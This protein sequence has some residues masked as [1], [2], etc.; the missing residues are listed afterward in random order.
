M[1]TKQEI[2]IN[3]LAAAALAG[4]SLLQAAMRQLV[5]ESINHIRYSMKHGDDTMKSSISRSMIPYL[6]RA[7]QSVDNDSAAAEE[8]LA[9][10]EMRQALLG[11]GPVPAPRGFTQ[12]TEDVPS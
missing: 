8:R 7:M 1:A 10:E 3:E 12:V 4:D 11:N 6:L 5:L 9:Y 2:S